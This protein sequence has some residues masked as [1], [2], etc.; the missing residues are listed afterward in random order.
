MSKATKTPHSGRSSVYRLKIKFSAS[1][2][3]MGEVVI[4]VHRPRGLSET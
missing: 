2:L 1:F 4:D 3:F